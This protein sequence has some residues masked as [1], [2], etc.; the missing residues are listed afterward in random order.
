L[1]SAAFRTWDASK[2]KRTH[3]FKT[4]D[5]YQLKNGTGTD[6]NPPVNGMG[7]STHWFEES[8]AFKDGGV[9]GLAAY[10]HGTRFIHI[11]PAGKIQ[12]AGYYVPLGAETSALH[13]IT[14]RIVYSIDYSRGIDI[15]KYTGPLE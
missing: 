6:G 5:S 15:L 2:W 1:Q 11:T 3:T 12:E 7:C 4:I 8:P 9:V 14:D 13:W 10:D